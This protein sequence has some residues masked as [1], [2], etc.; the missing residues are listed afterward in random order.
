MSKGTHAIHG[1]QQES[2][3]NG[4]SKTYTMAK[5]RREY[6]LKNRPIDSFF[7]TQIYQ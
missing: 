2:H 1:Q 4:Q 7:L 5:K 6:M 3:Q